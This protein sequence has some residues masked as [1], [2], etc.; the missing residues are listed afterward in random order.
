MIDGDELYDLRLNGDRQIELGADGDLRITNPIET[1]EQS[2]M[3][4]VGDAVRQLVGEPLTAQSYTD[5]E[6]R[7][8][9]A[10][11]RDTQIDDIRRVEVTRVNKQ[12]GTVDVDV[13]VSY[14]ESF[15]LELTT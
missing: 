11:E 4:H 2:V 3:I 14:N 8:R 7:I 12:N 13:Y 5:A 6:S 1:V 10:I 15:T 9:Q